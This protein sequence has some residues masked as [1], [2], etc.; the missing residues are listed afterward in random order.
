MCNL[1]VTKVLA[2][3]GSKALCAD[4][5]LILLG[6]LRGIKPGDTIQVYANLAIDKLDT[7]S[8]KGN[9]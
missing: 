1:E 6:N 5:R 8:L 2:V 4:G 3:T 7:D 9:N